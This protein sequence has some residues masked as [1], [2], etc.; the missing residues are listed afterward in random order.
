MGTIDEKKK[1]NGHRKY[2]FQPRQLCLEGHRQSIIYRV[3]GT[4]LKISYSKGYNVENI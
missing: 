1:L 4:L 2:S 3:K